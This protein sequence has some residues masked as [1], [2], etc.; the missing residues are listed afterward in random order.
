MADR[1]KMC[2]W[3]FSDQPQGGQE[4]GPNNAMEQSFK[5]HPYASLVRESIQNS[6]DAVLDKSQ[7]VLMR[8]EFRE[9]KFEDYPHLFEIG[10][11]IKG[12]ID[13][14]P[15]NKNAKDI[16]TP[17]LKLLDGCKRG[18]SLKYIRVSDFNTKGMKYS[19]ETDSPFYAFVRSA[20]V[21]AKEN[22]TA[23]GSF[24]FGKAAYF[25][26]SPISTI[27][28]SSYTDNDETYFEGVSSLCTHLYNGVKKMSVGYYDDSEGK[29]VSSPDDIPS[30]FR[31]SEPGTDINILGYDFYF[32]D[33]IK[34][35]MTEAVL[36]NF[37]MSIYNNRL[38]VK[39]GGD[40]LI[41]KDN[42]SNMMMLY[43]P[44]EED[45]T[46]KSGYDNPRP[47][48]DA[49]RLCET[50]DRYVKY[51]TNLSLIGHTTFYVNKFKG[52]SDKIAYVRDLQMLVFSK[53]N[54]TNYGFNAVFYCDDEKGNEILRML[55]NPAHDEWSA[56]NWPMKT[57]KG[58]AKQVLK[59]IEDYKNECLATLFESN[60]K[61][62]IDIKG[63]EQFLYIPTSLDDNEEKFGSPN[64][65]MDN[66]FGEPSGFT[67]DE[68][69][70]LTTDIPQSEDNPIVKKPTK[71]APTGQVLINKTTT[72]TASR[73]G[74]LRSGHGA[75]TTKPHSKGIEK[76]GDVGDVRAETPEGKEGIFAS[77]ISIPYRAFF[78]I[79]DGQIYHYVV[80]HSPEEMA[81]IRL[82]FFGVGEE[83]N[84]DLSPVSTNIGEIEGKII[85][86]IHLPE[87]TTRLKIRFEDNM[88][89]TLKLSAE[90]VY[91]VQ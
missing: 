81:S 63:L 52:V 36:R 5:K 78:Q 61:A 23:G 77:P 76:P 47:Y 48:Y 70:S 88:M 12:C 2:K 6:L 87:G 64:E 49:V 34:K 21:S 40:I 32:K 59:E 43:F 57:Q 11:H 16:Y 7:P 89:H 39:I 82:R 18:D 24:G 19:E 28:V 56:V 53:K 25:L 69:S 37:W 83:S 4:I 80:L 54:K 72:A 65:D 75:A 73:N 67:M 58:Y 29:P 85:R 55:E 30:V 62:A 20:G 35:E 45:K 44:E 8:Y 84:D 27:L 15:K 1:E 10:S 17:M 22:T 41:N 42:L 38:E 91:E 33:D 51:E 26:M 46:R 60:N 90:E 9:I 31:R 3:Y 74:T 50:S 68:G 71:S 79:E 66:L 13:Y 14:Y 86:D